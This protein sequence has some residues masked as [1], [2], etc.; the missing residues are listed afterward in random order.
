MNVN[1][2]ILHT[3]LLVAERGSFRRAAEDAHRSQGAVSMQIKQL[4][5]QLGVQLFHRTTRDVKLTA[6]GEHLL[7]CARKS[8][9]DLDQGLREIKDVI[10]LNKGHI[11]FSCIPSVASARLPEIIVAFQEAYPNITLRVEELPTPQLRES[12]RKLDID[13]AIAPFI[14]NATDFHFEVIYNE[15][16]YALIPKKFALAGR[17]DIT[18][19]ELTQMPIMTLT[20]S[21]DAGLRQTLAKALK[22]RGLTMQGRYEFQ[23]TSTQIEMAAAGIGVAILPQMALRLARWRGLQFLPI[24]DPSITRDLCIVT[25]RGR[26]LS[27]TAARLVSIVKEHLPA[28]K[29]RTPAKSAC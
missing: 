6:E 22:T 8:L 14:D 25:L 21:T 4:E 3:F 16:I 20:G 12:G 26:T 24:V 13:F 9:A 29:K 17:S 27:P 18:L 19:L 23:M 28:D 1:L 5:E 2:K 15:P 11:T 7:T 10:R